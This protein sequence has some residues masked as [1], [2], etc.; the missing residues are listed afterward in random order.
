MP[1]STG[2]EWRRLGRAHL[3]GFLAV[4]LL[5]LVWAPTG[6][7]AS[8]L[9]ENFENGAPG[10][11]MDSNWGILDFTNQAPYVSPDI[12]PPLVTLPDDGSLPPPAEGAKYAW[13]GD[14]SGT[15]GDPSNPFNGTYCFNYTTLSQDPNGGCTSGDGS[16][17]TAPV[18]GA[19]TS[20]TFNLS[21]SGPRPTLSFWA[22]FEIESVAPS[23]FDAM[24]VEGSNDGGTTWTQLA[25]LNPGADPDGGAPNLPF[26]NNGFNISPTFVQYSV[27]LSPLAGSA[28]AMIRFNFNSGDG[29]Y[30]GFRG[31][32]VDSVNVDDG[33]GGAPALAPGTRTLH[34]PQHAR[35]AG[36]RRR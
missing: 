21:G 14:Q 6:K 5:V 32:G 10:W 25:A 4:V 12:F 17:G 26:S 27:D 1:S 11:A 20:P 3:L 9:N 33:T 19:L 15:L 34:K 29:L 7:A 16:G 18:S 24:T 13:M 31:W 35:R 36:Q 28:N 23:S 8:I 2:F 22:F 30:N